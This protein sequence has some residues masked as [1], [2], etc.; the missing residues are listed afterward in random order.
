MCMCFS[1]EKVSAFKR[2]QL[3]IGFKHM[4][5]NIVYRYVSVCFLLFNIVT[6]YFTQSFV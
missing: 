5:E 4:F 6:P 3:L 1:T 2:F